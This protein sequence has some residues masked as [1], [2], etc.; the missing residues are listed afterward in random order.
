MP[1]YTFIQLGLAKEPAVEGAVD[2][3]G[4][5]SFREAMA[6]IEAALSF[7][8]VVSSF[9][10]ATSAVNKPGVVLFGPSSPEVWGHSNNINIYKRK[11]CAPCVDQLQSSACPYNKVCMRDITVDEVHSALLTVMKADGDDILQPAR[12]EFLQLV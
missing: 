11:R 6:L 12:K 10:H 7:V 2:F 3:R 5:T 4:K 1:D 9:A 8:G